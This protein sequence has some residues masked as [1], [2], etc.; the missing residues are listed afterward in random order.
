MQLTNYQLIVFLVL[1][2][3][4]GLLALF[5]LAKPLLRYVVNRII[6]DIMSKLLT[7]DYD[8]NLFELY[9]SLKRLS[10]LNLVEMS[11]RAETGKIVTR[12]LGS[13]KRFP[14]FDQLMFSP[15]QMTKLSLP[16]NASIDMDV[17]LGIQADK[18][19]TVKIPLLIGGM[20]YGL[21][22]SEEAKLALARASK[23][24]QTATCSG[25]GPF[26]PEEPEEAGKFILQ[27]CRWPT[28]GAR[29]DQ[30][31]A[32]AD[33]LEVQMGQGADVGPTSVE[34]VNFEG[35]AQQLSGLAPNE[36]AVALPAPPGVQSEADWPDFMRDLR[37]RANGIPIALKIMATDRLEEELSVAVSLGFD[38]IMI[39]G[40]G[41]GSHATA[42]V[43][44]DDFGI[45]ILYAL[46]RAK[47]YLQDKPI[48]LIVSGGFFTPGQCLKALALGADA[49]YLG[50]IPLLALTHNQV[51]K[52]TP[53]EPPTTLVYYNSP[54]KTQLDIDQA[55]ISVTNVLTSMVLE[56]EEAMRALGKSSLQELGPE[57]LIALD[58]LTASM[59]GVKLVSD[60]TSPPADKTLDQLCSALQQAYRLVN[61]MEVLLAG[62]STNH[63]SDP[64]SKKA[65]VSPAARKKK[66]KA[67]T[68]T[69]N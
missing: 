3:L 22:L 68:S 32:T 53:W 54:A 60:A 42:P 9:P 5:S 15:R 36:P 20:A 61:V 8:Q 62:L 19:L 14:G 69:G 51:D 31:I 21:A 48:S 58:T 40:A 43:K 7:E 1:L 11:L 49:I 46:K 56:M 16:E 38:V 47:R 29:T 59:T 57:D 50:T 45:P 64:L 41:G 18:P 27:I 34:A 10:V 44:Q 6:D 37:Q 4:L 24:L 25:E 35:R 65:P 63:F 2:L 52:A 55:A 12:P 33:M 28:W 26:L 67:G 17:I 39:D 13:P 23:L 30:E 66:L